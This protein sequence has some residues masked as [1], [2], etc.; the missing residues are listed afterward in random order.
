MNKNKI[1]EAMPTVLFLS[2][3]AGIFVSEI[4][5]ARDT[6]KAEK[7]I[8]DNVIIYEHQLVNTKNEDGTTSIIDKKAKR[9]FKEYA[10]D[11]VKATWKCYIP[12]TVSTTLTCI[13]LIASNRLTARQVALL[14]SAVASGGA[15]VQ[16]YRK[17]IIE[18]FGEEPLKEIDKAVAQA[19]LKE[20]NPPCINT[21]GAVSYS[22][23]DPKDGD[24]EC[25]FFDP[26]TKIK[27][28]STK[29]AVFGAKYYLNRNFAL[30]GNV[31]LEMFYNFLG[32]E[33]PEEY[34]YC[35]WD[36][37]ILAEDGYMWIDIDFTKSDEVDP[38]TGE[39]YYIIEYGFDPGEC[40][41]SYY[42]LGNPME[43]EGSYVSS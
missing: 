33:L 1:R 40:E 17:Q 34:K 36:C 19:T 28:R 21:S 25:L 11:V 23:F 41:D 6:L 29:L 31:P 7:I 24:E 20:S 3:I 8:E 26:F 38:E 18:K 2:G 27:F 9:P 13:A 15:L 14:S 4:L 5:V 16:K 12:S 10:P 39:Q 42:P 30:G 43:M 35:E 22:E 32:I 37:D